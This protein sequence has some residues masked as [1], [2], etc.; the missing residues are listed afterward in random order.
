MILTHVDLRAAEDLR[1]RIREHERE[2]KK[3]RAA[4]LRRWA[5]LV[6]RGVPHIAIAKAYRVKVS[7]V[8]VA[9]MRTKRSR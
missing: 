8:S 3:L 6:K 9:L 7:T 4:R 2:L 5:T 1:V